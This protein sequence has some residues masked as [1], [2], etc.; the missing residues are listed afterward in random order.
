LL[1][2]TSISA[3]F[4]DMGGLGIVPFNN[5]ES[6]FQ[7]L[8]AEANMELLVE[9]EA[10]FKSIANLKIS[11]LDLHGFIRMQLIQYNKLVL[12]FNLAK[13]SVPVARQFVEVMQ[14]FHEKILNFNANYLSQKQDHYKKI[15]P[16]SWEFRT[17]CRERLISLSKSS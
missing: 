16:Q 17:L 9:D 8:L 1:L 10:I 14:P 15:S 11:T 13:E 3:K 5:D 4:D 2:D 12:E 6:Y 7:F